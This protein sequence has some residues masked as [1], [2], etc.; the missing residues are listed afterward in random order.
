MNTL[1]QHI[2]D[3]LNEFDDICKSHE[4]EYSLFGGTHLGAIRHEGF[5]PWDDDIDIVVKRDQFEKLDKILLDDSNLK[6]GTF[7]QSFYNSKRYFNSTPKLRNNSMNIKERVPKTQ[8]L[9]SG[10][11]VDIF[12][13]DKIPEDLKEQERFFKRLKRIDTIVFFLTYVQKDE[14]RKGF[15]NS[16]KGFIQRINE[17]L[18]P[19]YF[20]IKPLIRYRNRLAQKYN[21]TD[22][23]MYG[24]NTYVFFRDFDE[25]K[26]HT[27]PAVN[28]EKIIDC[29]F[30]G[31]SFPGY[32]NY[33]ELLTIYYG[34]YMRIPDEE[35]RQIHNIDHD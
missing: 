29:T 1:Q 3:L 4:I 32:A 14:S 18:Y 8:D 26:T 13:W 10:P 23:N 16:L 12:I 19:L 33:D 21:V 25:F 28:L 2:Y 22:S 20:F 34:D 11:W 6:D 7:Y 17:V 30:E 15:R 9:Y 24:I 35:E 27:T 5:I 31:K